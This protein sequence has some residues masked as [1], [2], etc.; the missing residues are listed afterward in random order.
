MPVDCNLKHLARIIL[1]S[2]RSR[3]TLTLIA[4]GS[5]SRTALTRRLQAISPSTYLRFLL[6]TGLI[7]I[8]TTQSAF[9]LAHH[10]G[11][12][13]ARSGPSSNFAQVGP[14]TT[15][16]ADPSDSSLTIPIRLWYNS[17]GHYGETEPAVAR[18]IA[19]SLNQTCC[20]SV[21]LESEPWVQYVNDFGNGK[22]PFFLLGWYPD[23]YDPDDYASPFLGTA[24]AASLGSQYSTRT[25]DNWLAWEA[26]NSSSSVRNAL[27]TSI[28]SHLASADPY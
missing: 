4:N 7:A 12:L 14:V 8:L 23:Y 11:Q 16:Q 15:A 21:R 25:M 18:T 24:G 19:A 1:Y 20:L 26:G 10:S 9:P 17:D 13:S 6:L 2:D 3:A 27:F 22:L 5:M 28:H